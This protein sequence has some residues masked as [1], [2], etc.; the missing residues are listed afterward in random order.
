VVGT[1]GRRETEGVADCAGM[2]T[3]EAEETKCWERT[4]RRERVLLEAE[5]AGMDI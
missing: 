2:V 1:G 4:G 5:R 3:V